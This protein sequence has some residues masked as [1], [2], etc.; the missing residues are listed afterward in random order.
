M[1]VW[2]ILKRDESAKLSVRDPSPQQELDASRHS[3]TA[4]SRCLLKGNW[5]R[6]RQLTEDSERPQSTAYLKLSTCMMGFWKL[7]I[8]MNQNDLFS[9]GSS[10]VWGL[11]VLEF[12]I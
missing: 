9:L 6:Q 12:V 10:W 1:Y 5:Q 2:I 3:A 11:A 8:K 4:L 7:S